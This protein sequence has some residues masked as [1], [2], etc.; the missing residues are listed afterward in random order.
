MP[1]ALRLSQFFVYRKKSIAGAHELS[2]DS[3]TMIFDTSG[4][5]LHSSGLRGK[6]HNDSLRE[7]AGFRYGYSVCSFHFTNLVLEIMLML[8]LGRKRIGNQSR[9]KCDHWCRSVLNG[10]S[11]Q[12]GIYSGMGGPGGWASGRGLRN[13]DEFSNLHK[14]L[15]GQG[16][17]GGRGYEIGKSTG[18]G[19]YG[20]VGA[21]GLVEVF[22]DS[23]MGMI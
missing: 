10:S 4:A 16:P 23:S 21:G 1:M 17:G 7:N 11:G 5:W 22:P 9:W 13:T 14:A 12:R 15:D 2:I 8:R 18:G 3:G 19:S 20:G 6:E